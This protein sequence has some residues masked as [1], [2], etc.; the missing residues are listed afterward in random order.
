MDNTL[1]DHRMMYRIALTSLA[2]VLATTLLDAQPVLATKSLGGQS[3]D[4]R[5]TISVT[6]EATMQ[7]EPNMAEVRIGVVSEGKDVRAIKADNDKR[8]RAIF[9][10]LERV[11]IKKKDIKTSNV[12]ISPAYEYTS[13][14]RNLVKYQMSNYITVTITNLSTIE[15]VINEAVENGGNTLD[16]ISFSHSDEDKLRDSLRVQAARNAR[17]RAEALTGALDAKVI[18]VISIKA[19]ASPS[20]TNGFAMRG[21]RET[22]SMM[23]SQDDSTPV[24]AGTLDLSATVDVIFEIE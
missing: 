1:G 6:G 18:R 15:A 10:V 11:G 8:L 14:R 3:V 12:Q 7:L 4:Q 22:S 17:T 5:R 9:D 2:L 20:Y 23:V 19:N 21:S 13:G 16:N 24:G